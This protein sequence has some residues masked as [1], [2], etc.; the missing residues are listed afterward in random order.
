MENNLCPFVEIVLDSSPSLD[1]SPLSSLFSLWVVELPDFER[2]ASSPLMYFSAL[3][4]TSARL[5]CQFLEI[6]NIK[7]FN[8]NPRQ[9]KKAVRANFPSGMSTFKNSELNL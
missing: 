5:A 2:R 1:Y 9:A 6:E 8:W 4:R 3:A 7:S